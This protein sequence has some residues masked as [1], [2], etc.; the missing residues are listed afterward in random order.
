MLSVAVSLLKSVIKSLLALLLQ[1]GLL[2]ARCRVKIHAHTQS[3][4][5]KRKVRGSRD[6]QPPEIQRRVPCTACAPVLKKFLL[7][8]TAAIL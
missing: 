3:A 7:L 2:L 4:A 1:M 5:K 6:F 8:M